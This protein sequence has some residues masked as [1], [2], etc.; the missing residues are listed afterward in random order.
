MTTPRATPT[1]RPR[2]G[3]WRTSRG[4][5]PPSRSP[6]GG[7]RL[8]MRGRDSEAAG[9]QGRQP[10]AFTPTSDPQEV[11]KLWGSPK[12]SRP[13]AAASRAPS[14]PRTPPRPPAALPPAPLLQ[15]TARPGPPQERCDVQCRTL[16]DCVRPSVPACPHR[17]GVPG[18]C[19]G[20]AAGLRAAAAPMAA[21][22]ILQRAGRGEQPGQRP[23]E[24]LLFFF[25]LLHSHQ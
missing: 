19:H 3:R 24:L 13:H 12:G 6:R 7:R 14:P 11:P 25:N 20:V 9:A 23:W 10:P 16:C 18:K 1:P 4:P 21:G 17:V 5:L 15:G 8:R 22:P 2:P